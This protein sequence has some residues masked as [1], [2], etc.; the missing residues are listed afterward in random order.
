MYLGHLIFLAG[1]A[2]TLESWLAAL[3]TV[4]VAV[5]FHLRVIG[6]EKKLVVRLGAAYVDYLKSVKRWI[7]GFF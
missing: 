1:L 6:D 7:P 5:W 3:I 2:L 4:G